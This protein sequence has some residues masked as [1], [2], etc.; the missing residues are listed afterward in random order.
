VKEKNKQ[1]KKLSESIIFDGQK[2]DA[3]TFDLLHINKGWDDE[4]GDYAN[5][6]RSSYSEEDIVDFFEQFKY[7]HIEWELGENKN[8]IQIKGKHYYRYVVDTCN[9]SGE[10]IRIVIDLPKKQTGVGVIVTVFSLER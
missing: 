8:E 9:E 2:I 6:F 4:K 3:I 1:T 10:D 5:T 7:W